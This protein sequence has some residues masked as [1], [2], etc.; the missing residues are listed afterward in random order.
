VYKACPKK[1]STRE[2]RIDDKV[3]GCNICRVCWGQYKGTKTK[4]NWEQGFFSEK[5]SRC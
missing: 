1:H 4:G 2:A 3:R 5:Q